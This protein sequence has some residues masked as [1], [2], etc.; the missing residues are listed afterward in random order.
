MSTYSE[1]ADEYRALVDFITD[2]APLAFEDEIM[3]YVSAC[4]LRIWSGNEL[5]SPEYTEALKALTGIDYT[6]GQILTAMDCCADMSRAFKLPEFFGRVVKVNKTENTDDAYSRILIEKLN[7]LFVGLASVNG[8]FTIEEAAAITT[9]TTQLSEYCSTEGLR[10]RETEYDFTRHITNRKSDG[11][12]Q[13]DAVRP[14]SEAS[15]EKHIDNQSDNEPDKDTPAT[16][17]N[18]HF[19]IDSTAPN[20][21]ADSQHVSNQSGADET[22]ENLGHVK[23]PDMPTSPHSLNALLEELDGLIGLD[24]VKKDVHSLTN[25]IRVCGLRKERGFQ[26]PVISYHLVFTGNPGTGKTTVA[27][28]VAQLYYQM[29]LLAQGQLVEADRSTLVAGY[30]GQTAIKT[31]KVIQ[32]A[33]GGVLFIDEAYSL[34]GEKED[35]YGKEAIE[36]LL[37]AMEDHRDELVVIVAGYDELMHKFI[38]SNPGLRSRF[39]KYF[40]FP[41]YTGN[42]MASIFRRFCKTNGYTLDDALFGKLTERFG[43]MYQ[44]RQEH[45]GNA[46]TVRNLFERAINCQANRLAQMS[47]ISDA[48]LSAIN[49]DD[50]DN[51]F[52]EVE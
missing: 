33:L 12:W 5:F 15:E 20:D 50:I 19:H 27:R 37:K 8:D 40:H 47:D 9:I 38:N 48:S 1:L 3:R 24:T 6:P 26:V 34:A 22:K 28:L 25:F 41:D 49:A 45:F 39:N 35:S 23:Q 36:T 21:T 18:L 52:G 32:E 43:E 42:E 44:N 29:G 30:L 16:T 4:A 7:R 13:K 46:R 14:Q 51:A 17:V 2:Q 11:Y 31:Q 10:S